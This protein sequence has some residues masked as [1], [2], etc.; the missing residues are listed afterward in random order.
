MEGTV[1]NNIKGFSNWVNESYSTKTA[2]F[3]ERE[4]NILLENNKD[5]LIEEFVPEIL[6]LA[7]KFGQSGQ[8]GGSAPFTASALAE[9]IKKLCLQQ[10][11]SPI[12]NVDEDWNEVGFGFKNVFQN[13]R[14]YALFKEGKERPYYLDAIVW[15]DQDGMTW[16]GSA[17]LENGE[18]V[19]SRQYVKKFPFEPKT[20]IVDITDTKE[21]FIIKDPK[22]LDEVFKYYDKFESN[23]L[24]ESFLFEQ[25]QVELD[26]GFV[27]RNKLSTFY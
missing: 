7:E 11:I 14:C 24:N 3:A 26:G 4:L 27:Q 15:K 22:Q 18:R 8:S 1:K 20:F 25:V 10:P 2:S 5:L 16:S 17:I 21:D 19:L 6:S 23:K 12:R 13:N 9:T